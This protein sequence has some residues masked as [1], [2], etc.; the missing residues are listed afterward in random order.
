MLDDGT[1]GFG[2]TSYTGA[3]FF[4][5]Q[6]QNSGLWLEGSVR[7]GRTSSD[8]RGTIGTKD[9]TYDIDNNYYGAHLGVG[10]IFPV[11]DDAEVDIYGRFFYTHQDSASADVKV[12]GKVN[13][14]D[15]DATDSARLR[16][17]ARWTKHMDKRNSLYAGLA[18]EYEFCG[19]ADGTRVTATRRDATGTPSLK[20]SSGMF[21][22]G[23]LMNPSDRSPITLDLGLTGWVGRRQGFGA[24]LSMSWSL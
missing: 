4:V 6:D 24:H 14:F 10:K 16:L 17:G 22:F 19:D 5:R 8:Y 15:F 3:G 13:R 1:K 18:Y 23:W 20:G 7:G 2:D 12:N 21:E 11:K 9:T